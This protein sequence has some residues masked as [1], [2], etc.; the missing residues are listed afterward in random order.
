[1][2]GISQNTGIFGAGVLS[3]SLKLPQKTTFYENERSAKPE[4]PGNR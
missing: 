4:C 2:A 1:M 3:D